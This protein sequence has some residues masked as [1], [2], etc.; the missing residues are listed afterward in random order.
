MPAVAW[1]GQLRQWIWVS[2]FGQE[3]SPW[4]PILFQ[5]SSLAICAESRALGRDLGIY[6]ALFRSTLLARA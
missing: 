5:Q 6:P 4:T 1:T 3:A 2:S